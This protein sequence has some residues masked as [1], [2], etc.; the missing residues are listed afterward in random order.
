[1]FA[2]LSAFT[3]VYLWVE[4]HHIQATEV[5][6]SEVAAVLKVS[7]D[8]TPSEDTIRSRWDTVVQISCGQIQCT[9]LRA[10]AV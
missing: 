5:T 9:E 6:Q 1:M 2:V 4:K 10:T 7:W 8:V 3:R